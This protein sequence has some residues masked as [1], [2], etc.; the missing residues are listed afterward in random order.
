MRRMAERGAPPARR[1]AQTFRRRV[2]LDA[3]GRSPSSSSVP[4]ARP[5]RAGGQP[6]RH[7]RSPPLSGGLGAAVRSKALSSANGLDRGAGS[8]L[9][10]LVWGTDGALS[11]PCCRPRCSICRRADV[12]EACVGRCLALKIRGPDGGTW[13]GAELVVAALVAKPC[14]HHVPSGPAAWLSRERRSQRRPRLRAVLPRRAPA[15]PYRGTRGAV[16]RPR[17]RRVGP[18]QD[19][20]RMDR[21]S[22]SGDPGRR[23]RPRRCMRWAMAS[24]AARCRPRSPARGR[25]DAGCRLLRLSHDG[26]GRTLPTLR[27]AASSPS[28]AERDGVSRP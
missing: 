6:R 27:P 10:Q 21:L 25:G 17:T 14:F 15:L 1:P 7:R 22:R 3:P 4:A 20:A 28:T 5:L 12:P 2:G 26:R 23:Q 24:P 16:L 18:R 8:L 19:R 9:Q 11:A 13:R